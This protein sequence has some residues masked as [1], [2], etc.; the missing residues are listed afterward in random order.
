MKK[1]VMQ[2]EY[3]GRWVPK[4][5]FRVWM[6]GYD[7][8]RKLANSYKE[9][10]DLLATGEWFTTPEEA[11]KKEPVE[12]MPMKVTAEQVDIEKPK[13]ADKPKYKVVKHDA[14]SQGVRE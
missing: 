4:E 14:N 9:Y 5:H 13:K 8:T 10:I 7:N 12:E 11:V 3:L 6:H 2:V 1:K